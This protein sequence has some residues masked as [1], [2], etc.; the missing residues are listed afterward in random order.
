MRSGIRTLAALTGLLFLLPLAA[1]GQENRLKSFIDSRQT[2]ILPGNVHPLAQEKY[3]QG[4]ADDDTLMQPMTLVL[5][6]S[7]GQQAVLQKLLEDQQDPS[8]KEYHHWLTPEQ[9]GQRFGF[10]QSD[11]AKIC[12][13]LESQGFTVLHVPPSRNLIVFSGT[14]QTVQNAFRTAIHRY[15]VEGEAHIANSHPPELPAALTP[16]VL[17]I[18][19]LDDFRPKATGRWS[20][21]RT[22]AFPDTNFTDGSHGLG[23]A[24]YAV[25]YGILP[26]YQAGFN[27]SG[28]HIAVVGQCAIGLSDV[29]KFRTYFSLPANDPQLT[30]A[31]G[32]PDP[33]PNGAHPGDCGEAYLDVDWSGGIASGATIDY[34][35]AT[36]V[37]DAVQYAITH[38]VAPI[39][40]MSFGGCEQSQG[41]NA[42]AA[43]ES[44]AQQA[45]AQ[46]ITW[47]ASSGDAGAASCDVAFSSAKNEA[48]N[49][50]A[51]TFPASI[52]E[53]TGVGGTAFND[54]TGVYW[55]SANGAGYLSALSYIPEIGWNESG[56]EGLASSGGGLS[57]FYPKPA[58]QTG[59]GVPSQNQRAV[60]DVALTAA[61][62]DA[63]ITFMN[64]NEYFNAG[65]SAATP[66]FAGILA[67]L[68]QYGLSNGSQTQP[69]QGNI[70]PSLYR[71]SQSAPSAFHDITTGN[72]VVNCV[73][74]S[75]DCTAGSFGYYA[76]LGYD[77]VTGLGSIDANH[78]VS[79]WGSQPVKSTGVKVVT[80]LTSNASGF[81]NNVCST[82]SQVTNF[83]TLS[84]QVWV[85]FDVTGAQAGEAV[86]INF[87]RP[88]GAV[89]TSMNS[90][91]SS[92]GADGGECFSYYITMN[93]AAAASYPGTWTI[94]AFWDQSSTPL[95]TLNFNLASANQNQTPAL[96]VFPHIAS[97]SQWHTDIFVL[98]PNSTPAIFSLVFHT[99]TGA[100]LA[101]DGNPPTRNV[102]L[103]PNGIAFFR[104]SAIPTPNEGWAEVDASVPV[105]GVAVFG[106]RGDDGKY[107][108]ASVPLSA[109]YQSFAVPFDET[110]SPLGAPF[111]NGFAVTN[112]DALHAG[113]MTCT[114][115][116]NGGNVLGS[117]LRVGPLNPLQH[118]EFLIDQQFGSSLAGQ[119]GTLAC[120]SSTLVAAVELRAFSSS[121]AVSSMPVIASTTAGSSAQQV[122]PH[123]AS[124]SQWHTDIFILNTNNTPA[125][126]SL[127]V[128][129][130]TGAALLLDGNPPTSNLTLPPS[131][132]AFFRTAATSTPNE[133]WAEVDASVPLSGVAVFGRRGDDGKYYEAS[134][135]LSAPYQSFTVPFDETVSPLGAPFLNG[136]AVTN[137]DATNAAQITCTAYGNGGGVLG[138]AR[139][140]GPLSPLQHT[141]FLIDQQ[142]GSSLVGQRGTLTCQSSTLVAAVELRAF[143]SSPAV[144]S[145]P[146]IVNAAT[147]TLSATQSG[148]RKQRFTGTEQ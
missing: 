10:S 120:Q 118:T 52:P 12:A 38:N 104:T 78:L 23:P 147:T 112:T 61:M 94:A 130:D 81:V 21:N 27:G 50:L 101:L 97:D 110:V 91:I 5:K 134:V 69:G 139:Q 99:D 15:L 24:D 76:G 105:S 67:I 70:N 55:N 131:G 144:S 145:M 113:Q 37:F 143:S 88:D 98:N 114:V 32:S 136:F 41:Q 146:V 92:V 87:Y 140:V 95:F 75:T 7:A 125:T 57:V 74:G 9:F 71:L 59:P 16:F 46:G 122:F 2:V 47:L 51:V 63:Y 62:H 43:F 93:G 108:E 3:D 127:V 103:A 82:P 77:L 111:L 133:G 25:I 115:Y 72:N 20:R 86:A 73:A 128:H 40:T 42:L 84:P 83:T 106:R 17:A 58:W 117:G 14:V 34:V 56:P 30:L 90:S 135:P 100:P 79:N 121:P 45:N 65:T 132:V 126:F 107:Y 31:A 148:A 26:L 137:T 36:N 123:I 1:P 141:E 49:G 19:G 66:S 142:F 29:Q 33:G 8:S 54:S 44:I 64:G 116:G 119:R 48:S 13:W 138:S 35:Y 60:P 124:D 28:Q 109:P 68:N 4:P 96:Q 11:I 102:T 129:T 39:V 80:A 18:N 53:V 6:R 22:G 85:Y 89:Y